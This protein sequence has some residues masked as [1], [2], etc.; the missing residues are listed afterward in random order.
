MGGTETGRYRK[1]VRAQ[2]G[3][4]AWLLTAGP[5]LAANDPLHGFRLG[6][7]LDEARATAAAQG[8]ALVPM[9]PGLPNEWLIKGTGLGLFVCDDGR[10][11]ALR[12]QRPGG[13]DAF[14]AVISQMTPAYGSPDLRVAQ[15]PTAGRWLTNIEAEFP[16]ADPRVTVTLHATAPFDRSGP[17]QTGLLVNWSTPTGCA[18]AE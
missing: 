9:G 5:A 10:V 16:A 13:V 7:T 18:P 1:T 4:L 3:A 6:A 14:G 12:D 8:W 17:E 15:F 2:L 11:A